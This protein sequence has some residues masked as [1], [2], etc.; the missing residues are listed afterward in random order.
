MKITDGMAAHTHRHMVAPLPPVVTHIPL[1]PSHTACKQET[2]VHGSLLSLPGGVAMVTGEQGTPIP[3]VLRW[4]Q[5]CDCCSSVGSSRVSRV[6]AEAA[7]LRAPHLVRP[8][9]RHNV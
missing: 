8:L 4:R 3:P 2:I 7:G 6:S 1:L 9:L 5:G